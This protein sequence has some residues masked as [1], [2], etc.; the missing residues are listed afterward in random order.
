MGILLIIGTIKMRNYLDEHIPSRK[1]CINDG[2]KY[3]PHIIAIKP[4]VSKL[5]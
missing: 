2:L 4:C 1:C 3:N 5:P